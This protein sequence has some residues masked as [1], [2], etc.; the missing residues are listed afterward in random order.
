M[1][2]N[3]LEFPP[4]QNNDQFAETNHLQKNILLV[5]IYLKTR[6]GLERYGVAAFTIYTCYNQRYGENVPFR[7]CYL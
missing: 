5:L 6:A 2:I 1:L 7:K 4:R 3:S